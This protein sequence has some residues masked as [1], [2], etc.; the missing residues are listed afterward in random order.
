MRLH[1]VRTVCGR[2][3]GGG[4]GRGE[5]AGDILE[6]ESRIF[7]VKVLTLCCLHG[8]FETTPN[9]GPQICFCIVARNVVQ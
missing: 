6:F 3:G 7:H 2:A 5:K 9:C 4:G 1:R 8:H